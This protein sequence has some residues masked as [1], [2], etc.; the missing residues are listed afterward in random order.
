MC[1]QYCHRQPKAPNSN[2]CGTACAAKARVACLLCKS[3]PKYQR[4]HLCG[5]SCKAMATKWTP[6]IL[7][8]P[9]GHATFAFGNTNTH[10]NSL[11]LIFN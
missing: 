8:A 9:A 3:R 5:K 6:L 11:Y 10:S 2:Q 4:Y 1:T 7:E